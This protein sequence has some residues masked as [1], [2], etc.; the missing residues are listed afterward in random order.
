MTESP[1]TFMDRCYAHFPRDKVMVYTDKRKI[2][3]CQIWS[4]EKTK[5]YLD[6]LDKQNA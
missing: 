5:Q 2:G 3:K 4:V 6:Y 1:D